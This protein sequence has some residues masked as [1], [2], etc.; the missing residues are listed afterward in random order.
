MQ[1]LAGAQLVEVD[2]SVREDRALFGAAQN[3]VLAYGRESAPIKENRVAITQSISGIGA[4]RIGGEF[5]AR[6]FPGSKSIY[7]PNPTQEQWKE[8]SKVVKE[9]GH[10]PF[11]DMAY[12]DFASGDVD[13]DAF[14]LRH[15]IAEG[16]Q[17]ALS[18]SFAKAMDGSAQKH[19]LAGISY[20]MSA[21]LNWREVIGN[22]V[23]TA[24]YIAFTLTACALFSKT[25]IEVSG[26]GPRGVAKHLEES[27]MVMAGH[28]EQSMHKELKRVIPIGALSVC[29]DFLGAL[30]SGTGILL[31]VTIIYSY[32]EV[33]VRE[34]SGMGIM[35]PQL[36]SPSPLRRDTSCWQRRS[37]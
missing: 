8:I 31:A 19:A 34:S 3:I 20:Y 26:S 33:S 7:L 29:A 17:V 30:G 24:I 11:F 37:Q 35:P 1:L 21:P 4:L 25:W 36:P 32:F 5:L 15:F 23:H 18:Q 27:G 6:H 12:Q 28:R 10:F 9:K 2:F 14:A 22:P 16:H 13:R